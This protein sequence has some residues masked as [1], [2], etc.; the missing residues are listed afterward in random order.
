MPQ[1]ADP[2]VRDSRTQLRQSR[3]QVRPSAG[4]CHQI[5]AAKLL[6]RVS[7]FGKQ[8]AIYELQQIIRPFAVLFEA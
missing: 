3:G 8:A 5:P 2:C 4:K 6:K 1:G 7:M